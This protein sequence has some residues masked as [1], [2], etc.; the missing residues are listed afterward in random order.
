MCGRGANR[1]ASR[2]PKGSLYA[3]SATT[4]AD[5]CHRAGPPLHAL[6]GD[7]TLAGSHSADVFDGGPGIDHSLQML[8]GVD[9]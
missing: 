7:D 1:R 5:K 3:D 6:A 9:T 2:G 4:R 8:D